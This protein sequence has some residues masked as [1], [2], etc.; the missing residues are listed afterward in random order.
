MKR[1]CVNCG[2]NPGFDPI[3]LAMARRLGQVFVDR[4]IELIFGGAEVGLMGERDMILM[5]DTPESL[6][7]RFKSYKV[8]NVEK[9]IGIKSRT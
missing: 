4:R 3:Y 7:D 2:S 8:P 9:W 1:I 6:L 5:E